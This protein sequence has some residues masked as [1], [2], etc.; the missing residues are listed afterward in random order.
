MNGTRVVLLRVR[1]RVLE[2]KLLTGT[3][4]GAVDYIPRITLQSGDGQQR[5]HQLGAHAVPRPACVRH[6]DQQE[7]GADF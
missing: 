7:P 3:R 4:A 1:E 5:R 6:D 2:V